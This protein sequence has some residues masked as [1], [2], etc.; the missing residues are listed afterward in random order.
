MT[1]KV[2]EVLEP[3]QDVIRLHPS[4]AEKMDSPSFSPIS[5]QLS[6]F[7]PNDP[8]KSKLPLL[9]QRKA[10]SWNADVTGET[11]YKWDIPGIH[12]TNLQSENRVLNEVYRGINNTVG[13]GAGVV[14]YANNVAGAVLIDL[15]VKVEEISAKRGGPNYSELVVS[16]QGSTP[17]FPL[18]DAFFF[19]LDKIAQFSRSINKISQAGK[20]ILTEKRL[21]HIR[22]R[23]FTGGGFKNKSVFLDEI[24]IFELVRKAEK[25]SPNLQRG[26]N[27]EWI[28]NAGK[29]IGVDRST[30][31]PTT[32]YTIISHSSG[33]VITLFPGKP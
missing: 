3:Q 9:E 32:Q 17:G 25:I 1:H 12:A 27:F 20:L 11:G 29:V 13:L 21:I 22:E 14:N 33:E 19:G 8:Q 24:D 28:V 26:G 30:K 2:S 4:E 31:L 7:Q 6:S 10:N 23:H 16:A 15:P 5:P 18:D